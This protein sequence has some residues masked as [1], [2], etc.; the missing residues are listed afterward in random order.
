MKRSNRLM[1]VLGV[2]LALVAFGGVLLFGSGSGTAQP[3]PTTASVVTAAA[4][5]PLGTALDATMLVVVQKPL[6]ETTDTYADP[7]VLLGKVVRQ[8]VNAGV[9][10][11]PSDFATGG[12]ANAAQ[13]TSSLKAGQVAISVQIDALKGVG[14]FIQEGDYVDVLLTTQVPV[15]IA[16]PKAAGSGSGSGSD[17]PFTPI[18]DADEPTSVKVLV[19][20]VQVLAHGAAAVA[21]AANGSAQ[22]DPATGQPVNDSQI[23]ILSVTAQQAEIIRYGQTATAA[24]LS[25]VLR[26]PADVTAVDT[27]TTGITLRELVDKYGVLPPQTITVAYP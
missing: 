25:L 3:A 5:I 18:A 24:T 1:L 20:N 15:V 9:A 16:A 26:A 2:V 11:K 13:V 10:L 21:T 23:L 19:R 14:G 12:V 7:A 4:D 17:S 8:T 27:D 22:V 6:A